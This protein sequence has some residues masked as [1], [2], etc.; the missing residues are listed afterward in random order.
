M[1]PESG[2]D[3][4]A[5]T[6]SPS[7][8]SDVEHH[9]R[10]L[11]ADLKEASKYGTLSGRRRAMS[12]AEECFYAPAVRRAALDLR[13]PT[14]S[15]PLTSGWLSAVFEAQSEFSYWLHGLDKV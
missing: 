10:S 3:R 9:Y 7:E 8:R 6:L 4:A 11:K 15:N 12:R 5:R 1:R 13:P 2:C 14:N